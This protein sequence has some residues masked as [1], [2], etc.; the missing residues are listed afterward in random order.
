MRQDVLGEAATTS[1]ETR[2]GGGRPFTAAWLPVESRRCRPLQHHE[3]T[4]PEARDPSTDAQARAYSAL[5]NSL[6]KWAAQTVLLADSEQ[7]LILQLEQELAAGAQMGDIHCME[8]IRQL[9]ASA[10]GRI[11]GIVNEIQSQIAASTLS[12]SSESG[13][14]WSPR[15][16]GMNSQAQPEC[17][18]SKL[19]EISRRFFDDGIAEDGEYGRRKN[20]LWEQALKA[21]VLPL[22][23]GRRQKNGNIRGWST[24]SVPPS[25]GLQRY[26][27]NFSACARAYS[28]NDVRGTDKF[29]R[30]P[31][32]VNQ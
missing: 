7:R 15:Y 22:F 27:H 6:S 28:R 11:G 25:F 8:R 10:H 3:G 13:T 26:E 20:R 24:A 19:G 9:L 32:T 5:L 30:N 2:I 16:A 14:C 17:D 29:A 31:A 12:D 21:S 4:E 1:L 18:D 23:A